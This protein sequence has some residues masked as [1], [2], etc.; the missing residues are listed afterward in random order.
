MD[1]RENK[2][3]KC[4]MERWWRKHK[5][6]GGSDIQSPAGAGTPRLRRPPEKTIRQ[7]RLAGV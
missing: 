1:E 7:I 6:G 5:K 4:A 2:A 3:G